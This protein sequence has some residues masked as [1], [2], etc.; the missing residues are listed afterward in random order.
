MSLSDY[1]YLAA[2]V[3]AFIFAV[4]WIRANFRKP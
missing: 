2:C 3:L 1:R 4:I